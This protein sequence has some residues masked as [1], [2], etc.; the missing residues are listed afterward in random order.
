MM[1]FMIGEL[2][3]SNITFSLRFFDV[4]FLRFWGVYRRLE[5]KTQNLWGLVYCEQ[6]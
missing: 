1:G 5:F 2:E 6:G 4:L 3:P